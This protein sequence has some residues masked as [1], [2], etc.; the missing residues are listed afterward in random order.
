LLVHPIEDGNLPPER[1]SC[2]AAEDEGD[3]LFA[4]ER[5]QPHAGASVDGLQL[6]VRRDQSGLNG[7]IMKS[8][9][10]IRAMIRPNRSGGCRMMMKIAVASPM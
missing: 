10:G 2:V 6:E 1:R 7:T 4:A 9:I 3:G 5:R 8:G